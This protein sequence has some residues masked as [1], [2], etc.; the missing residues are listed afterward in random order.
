MR[1]SF[2]SVTF[3]LVVSLGSVTA[4]AQ[5]IYLLSVGDTSENSGLSFSTG[6]DLGYVFDAFYA[7]V[8]GQQLVMY[9]SDL[10]DLADGSSIRLAN[11]WLGPD[12]RGD[13]FDL[14]N[15]ILKAI[16]NCPAGQNDTVVFFFTGHGAFD[17]N[18]HFLVMPDGENRLYRKT[19]LQRVAQKKPRLMV[20]I[21]DSC[22]L[23]VPSGT[24]PLPSAHMLPP[25][26]ISPL[27]DSLFLRSQGVVDLNSS[28]EGEI[29]VG[30]IGGGLLTLS[31]AYMGNQPTFKPYPGFTR[32]RRAKDHRP[33]E[34]KIP[35][36]DHSKAMEDFFGTVLEHGLHADFDPN[37]P[38]F[39][40]FFANQ[41][42]PLTWKAVSQ[43]LN[44]K[45]DRLFKTIAPKGWEV[46]GRKQITQ[47]PR[48]YS[49]AKVVGGGAVQNTPGRPVP[50]QRRW[51]QPIY[52][53]EVG[54]RIL[55][56][57]GQ[58]IRNLNDFVRAVKSSP[59][60]MTFVLW[61][62]RTGRSFTMRTQLNPQNANSRFGVGCANA[63]GGGVSV[64]YV[65]SGYP[66][67]RC[68]LLE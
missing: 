37:K 12:V 43:L 6:P 27:F 22:N 16:D 57:N 14:K 45:V 67:T 60:T 17:E 41:N 15:K 28:S 62:A 35:A 11:P 19:I 66:G 42:Q 33:S 23:H 26:R 20:L 24:R 30:A 50:G 56:V 5:R 3:V 32:P 54:D 46:N 7:N 64:Q 21:T 59:T 8:P 44:T 55:Q 31:L 52:R 49:I 39:G 47:T 58:P 38:A 63:Q 13:L 10:T 65:M 25:E 18:G 68:Q 1:K 61:E 36:M 53:P 29:S 40:I 51:S 48:F 2:L 4:Q 9:N 34:A